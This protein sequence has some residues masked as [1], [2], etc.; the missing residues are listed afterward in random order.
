MKISG[1]KIIETQDGKKYE[2]AGIAKTT[3]GV[4]AGSLLNK[5]G[6]VAGMPI[7]MICVSKMGNLSRSIDTV[8]LNRAIDLAHE[9]SGLKQA[10]VKFGNLETL[11]SKLTGNKFMD[12]IR[13]FKDI[14]E[15]KNACYEP[16]Q[17]KIYV[18]REKLGASA[19][20]E[21]GHALN[22]NF[23][24]VGKF[25][26]NSRMP[27]MV[28][29]SLK[30]KKAEGEKPQGFFDKTTTFIKENIGKLSF[31]AMMPI[32]VEELMATIKGNKMAAKFLKPENLK[33]VK[34]ANALGLATYIGTAAIVGLTARLATNLKDKI[35]AP[36]EIKE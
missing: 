11:K 22:R 26:Q 32:A 3:G 24:K 20:H 29:A 35:A 14:I 33:K 4:V 28:V 16:I 25:L 31:A 23:S 21:M 2:K 1:N 36:K 27:L 13:G 10:G 34:V 7:G 9:T 15:G 18:N 19:F 30:R 17:N 5:V 6:G 12:K 8:E